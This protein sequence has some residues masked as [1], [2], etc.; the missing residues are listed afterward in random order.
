MD[1]QYI[2]SPIYQYFRVHGLLRFFHQGLFGKN[3]GYIA[4]IFRVIIF[5]LPT[6]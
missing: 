4:F 6:L 1:K 2:F 5:P 3:F